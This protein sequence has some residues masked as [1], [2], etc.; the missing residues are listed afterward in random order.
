MTL[1]ALGINHKTAPVALREKVAFTPDS[2]VEALAS[3]KK[4]EGVDESVIVSTCNRT[5]LYVN[6]QDES[7]QKLLQW[8]SD[9]HHLDVQE[10]SNN[11][12]VLA[13]DEAVKHIMRVASGLDSLILG[14]PQIL[15]QVKQAFGDA[16]HSG[17][18]NSEFDKLFQ[19]TF[20]VAKRVRSETDIGANAV[21]VAYAAVQLAK[22]IFAELPKRSVLLVGA[23]ETIEL[24]AQHLK[25]Q[26]VSKIAVANRTVARA[27][28]LAETLGASVYTLSQV[29]EHLKD[30][31]IVIS[32]TASQLPLIGKGMVEKAL[33]QRKNM[34]MFLVDLAVPR[35]IES[36]VNDLGDAYLYTVDDL[37]HI[38]QKNLEN[39][40]QAAIEAEKLIDKQAGDYMTW[41][42]SQ[43]SID[44][45]RQYRQK[46]MAQR[47][48]IVEKAKAQLAE[49]KEAEAVLEEMAYKLTNAL[50]HPTTLA[51]REAAMHDDPALSRWLGQ[52][53]A[54]SDYMSEENK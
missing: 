23:G 7:G 40:E 26:G 11:S 48:D 35:D 54:L 3:L 9:F 2:L 44:L 25:E 41:K 51:L 18:I 39:R 15:G 17:M 36:E 43:Q 38:V 47:D 28:A 4:L 1:L 6:T 22:H 50:L 46:G 24:V 21:S 5:E 14:E 53:L 37:Q 12:Y 49:G 10:I 42:Q 32:S 33:K 27:E 34:P 16:K 31:D 13:Q 30:F 52:A 19:H 29:P 8:L 20:S 45:V